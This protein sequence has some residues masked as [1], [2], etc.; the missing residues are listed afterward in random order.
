MRDDLLLLPLA[1]SPFSSRATARPR[2]AAS[3]AMPAPLMPP[4]MIAMSKVSAWRRA[5]AS[6]RVRVEKP[7]V[8]VGGLL[9]NGCLLGRRQQL[10]RVHDTVRVEG[11]LE[12]GQGPHAAGGQGRRPPG[13]GD[14]AD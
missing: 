6:A 12:C 4:P 3:R 2:W 8:W 7:S 13:T 5:G 11:L 14:P 1:K 10:A 9:I